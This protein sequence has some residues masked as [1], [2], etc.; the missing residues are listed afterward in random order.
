MVVVMLPMY[1]GFCTMIDK[2]P[3][4]ETILPFRIFKLCSRQETLLTKFGKIGPE[5]DIL[6]I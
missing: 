4:D 5:L 1:S 6:G 2:M 3:R